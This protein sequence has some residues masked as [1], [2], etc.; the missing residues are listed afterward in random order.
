[1]SARVATPLA[2]SATTPSSITVRRLKPNPTHIAGE[3]NLP[4]P[5]RSRRF[6]RHK[7]DYYG[8]DKSLYIWIGLP[9]QAVPPATNPRGLKRLD[10]SVAD[11][12]AVDP[13]RG[14]IVFPPDHSPEEVVWV[15]Y[16]YAFSAD[17]GGG[18]YN[19]P[20]SQPANYNLYRVGE[21]ETFKT[22]NDA[23]ARWR[24]DG[25]SATGIRRR[26]RLS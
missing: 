6:E 12:R 1:M 9:R 23:L 4:T 15:S 5:I 8:E 21:E 25:D 11:R 22:I 19:R 13:V 2:C 17:I 18:E 3:L 10:I 14:R 16:R 24:Q 26:G 7:T 20:L